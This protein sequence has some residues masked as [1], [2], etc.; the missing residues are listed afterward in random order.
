M[1][2]EKC[3]IVLAVAQTGSFSAAAAQNG[4]T[5]AG[6]SYTVDVVEKELGFSLFARTHG[7]VKLTRAGEQILPF[8]KDLVNAAGRLERQASKVSNLLWGD[9]TIGSFSS[10]A[11]KFMP[12]LLG[13]FKKLY[14]DVSVRIQEGVQQDLIRMV[15]SG[16]ADFVICSHQDGVDCQFIPLRRDEMWC[17]IPREHPLAVGESVMPY[18]LSGEDLIMPAYGEDPDVFDLLERFHINANIRYSTVETDTAYA[19]M[20]KGLG[21]VVTNEL[22][23]ENKVFNGVPLPFDP[24][25]YVE[26]G[27]YVP[28]LEEAS[29]S[30]RRFIAYLRENI[31]ALDPEGAIIEDVA[32]AGSGDDRQ[33]PVR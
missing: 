6:I 24:P 10:I 31:A 29:P 14:P 33:R 3:K 2:T 15:T 8:I 11:M 18:K 9:V 4:Y 20:E 7:G 23:M 32:D 16:G 19:L 17:V 5:P 30:A 21:I 27:I 25:Q 22:A 1:D 12:T 26:E 13:D 28:D